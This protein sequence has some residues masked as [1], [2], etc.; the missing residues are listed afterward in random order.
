MDKDEDDI[1]HY[2]WD[3]AGEDIQTLIDYNW[4]DELEDYRDNCGDGPE[5]NQRAGHIFETLVRLQNFLLG[6][7]V[8]P[9]EYL[10]D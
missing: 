9:A 6:T 2:G 3:D 5:D 7:Q 1:K 8:K 10:T 4:G